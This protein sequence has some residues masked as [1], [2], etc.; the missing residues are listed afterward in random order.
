MVDFTKKIINSNKFRAP[1]IRFLETGSYCTYPK[2]TQEYYSYWDSEKEKC[3]KGYTSEDGDYISGYNYFYLNY[4]PIIRIVW[5]DAEVNGTTKKIRRSYRTFPDFYDY[6]Y[7]FFS[8]IDEA[9]TEGR[10]MAVSKSRRK[11]YS[12]KAASMACRNFFL[13]PES[14]TYI[15]ASNKQYLTDDGIL[16]KAWDYMDFIDEHTAWG[17]KRQV[18]NTSMRRRASMLV[19]DEYGNKIEVGYKS[20]IIGVTL[21]DNPDN[22]RGKRGKLIIFE[23]AGSFPEL[24]AA[25]QIARPSVE[26]DGMTFGLMLAFGTGGDEGPAIAALKDMFYH[27]DS[28]NCKEFPNIWDEGSDNTN[29]GFFI[30]QYTNLDNRDDEGNRI[31]M[32]KDGNT[33]H[34][35]ARDFIMKLRIE[36][37]KNATN[38]Q[39][40]DRYI[41]ERCTCP[42]EA[43]MEFSGN[44][45]PKKEL[46]RHLAKIRTDKKLK[47]LKQIGDLTW[48]NGL[49][50]WT[51]K[52]TGDITVYPLPK[53][54]DPTGSIVI[55]EHPVKDAPYGMYILGVD[56]YDHD[57]SGTNSLGSCLV[58]KRFQNFE[59]YHDMIVAE[60]TGRPKTAEEFYENVRKL[61]TYYNGKIM[62]ENQNKGLFS[63]F[64]NKHSD[65][66]LADQPEIL[67]DI[68][69]NS[70]VQRKKG[71]HM[72]KEIKF[73]CEGKIKEYLEEELEPGKLQLTTIMSEPLLEEL[74]AYN[75]KGNFDR[76]M[77][78]CQ[79]M[80]FK[81]QIFKVQVKKKEDTGKQRVLFDGPIFMNN[82]YNHNYDYN[83]EYRT[84]IDDVPTF[85]FT[86]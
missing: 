34:G 16:T 25:W 59:S 15:Y 36:S 66:M 27:P 71:C 3:I 50:L 28:Y 74:I 56:P 14:K 17:K 9:E 73:W 85:T 61:A 67:N 33:L 22:V 52:K 31:Y 7:Y 13:I 84:M 60:Y 57:Q 53:N 51:I 24:G 2:G 32:D 1:A 54:A 83:R 86:K 46:Q 55:W 35:K 49:P 69:N 68:V 38:S 77:G 78:L 80:I 47:N 18:A 76:V 45:F 19:T 79:I 5:E 21:K 30:P 12:Y 64:V 65:W 72:N 62:Y 42:A 11:G 41:A 6:D 44:I 20:E 63:Y 39:A 70:K 29:C 4:S 75:D 40:V 58:Y 26:Q 81:E 43:F 10:H 8:G 48:E 82:G 23:E 37:T